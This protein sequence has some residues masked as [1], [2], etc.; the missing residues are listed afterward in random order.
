MKKTFLIFLFFISFFFYSFASGATETEWE[1][2]DRIIRVHNKTGWDMDIY[3]N[4]VLSKTETWFSTSNMAEWN[5][6]YKEWS[7]I[8]M[9]FCS[10]CRWWSTDFQ[11]WYSTTTWQFLD[12]FGSGGMTAIW[13]R[14]DTTNSYFNSW[15]W[16][17]G[18]PW[19]WGASFSSTS[20][21]T[22]TT[23]Y[24]FVEPLVFTYF[25][26]SYWYLWNLANTVYHSWLSINS[27]GSLDYDIEELT[28]DL[29]TWQ[30]SFSYDP[31]SP[32]QLHSF[33]VT[34]FW[35]YRIK[36]RF[37]A[38]LWP[39]YPVDYTSDWYN[40]SYLWPFD[41]NTG[42]WSE[43][44]W[45]WSFLNQNTELIN[46]IEDFDSNVDWN[47]SYEEWFNGFYWTIVNFFTNVSNSYNAIRDFFAN[48][49]NI[50]KVAPSTF[51][52]TDIFFLQT[53]ATNLADD[54]F[55]SSDDESFIWKI[56]NYFKYF[57][58]W[59]LFFMIVIVFLLSKK[60]T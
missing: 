47:V 24:W 31:N 9:I 26:S 1:S 28:W 53:N 22:P 10:D 23:P 19:A 60:K 49:F 14:V 39:S 37:Y 44:Y 20:W 54:F 50:W 32:N 57:A 40:F 52:F 15:A 21:S 46:S 59:L 27:T 4:N 18:K 5:F 17:K 11:G 42:S 55:T 30:T 45:T 8:F 29:T 48:L 6:N 51:S 13:P 2:S 36:F 38:W 7:A 16:N 25:S 34:D 41:F 58:V 35:E 3:I 33:T 43:N 56:V 12:W